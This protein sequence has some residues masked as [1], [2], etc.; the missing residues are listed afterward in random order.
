M[1]SNGCNKTDIRSNMRHLKRW[2]YAMHQLRAAAGEAPQ[3]KDLL[4][5]LSTTDGGEKR[6]PRGRKGLQQPREEK[7]NKIHWHLK[8]RR[9]GQSTV[10][11]HVYFV[12]WHEC[13]WEHFQVS[14]WVRCD[15]VGTVAPMLVQIIPF[16]VPTTP[17]PSPSQS[18]HRTTKTRG[19]GI[20]NRP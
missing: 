8:R 20:E 17:R 18:P 1:L 12:F 14:L 11:Q 15:V 3:R 19:G 4:R 6:A 2:S 7:G 13:A 10:T 5:L 16:Y 9:S